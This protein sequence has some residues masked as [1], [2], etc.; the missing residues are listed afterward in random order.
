MTLG[1]M[2]L[3]PALCRSLL[4][5]DPPTSSRVWQHGSVPGNHMGSTPTCT[6]ASGAED[7][8]R[9]GEDPAHQRSHV[10]GE[11]DKQ[12]ENSSRMGSAG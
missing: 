6:P 10:A 3:A 11:E 1:P 7:R 8:G 5:A 12:T 9:E 4:E 2:L